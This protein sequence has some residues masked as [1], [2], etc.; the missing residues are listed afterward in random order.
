MSSR[1]SGII[2]APLVLLLL[3][4]VEEEVEDKEVGFEAEVKEDPEGVVLVVVIEVAAAVTMEG[5]WS[6]VDPVAVPGVVDTP[7][8]AP[9]AVAAKEVGLRL[10]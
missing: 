9:A 1:I 8:A 10:E 7:A 2:K 3:L 6:L 5:S 4:F